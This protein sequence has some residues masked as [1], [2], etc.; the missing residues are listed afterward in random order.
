MFHY[1][2]LL[3]LTM[4]PTYIVLNNCKKHKSKS[5]II[6]SKISSKKR[7]RDCYE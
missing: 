3:G 4:I 2:C 7:K 1:I 6:S 5:S